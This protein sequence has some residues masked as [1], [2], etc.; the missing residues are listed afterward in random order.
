VLTLTLRA[1][2]EEQATDALH[3]YRFG[4]GGFMVTAACLLAEAL[5][6]KKYLG[7]CDKAGNAAAVFFLFLFITCFDL[8]IDAASFTYVAEVW[9]T[10]IR[11][12]SIALAWFA[13][14][15]G[16]ITFRRKI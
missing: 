3:L 16:A 15:L 13:Y 2:Y 14:F 9:P 7:H 5:L 10:T 12:K 1:L 8:F 11:S 4:A 6:R